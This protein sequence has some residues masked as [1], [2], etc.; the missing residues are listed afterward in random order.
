[1][2][3]SIARS[4]LI[5]KSMGTAV[6]RGNAQLEEANPLFDQTIEAFE[7]GRCD[8]RILDGWL[9]GKRSLVF[10]KEQNGLT[11]L[12]VIVNGKTQYQSSITVGYLDPERGLTDRCHYSSQTK[13]R[14]EHRAADDRTNGNRRNE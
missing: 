5:G 14:P 2:Y 1:M 10:L 11:K 6:D 7:A 12:Y 13:Q 9:R 3:Y 8:Y 4:R